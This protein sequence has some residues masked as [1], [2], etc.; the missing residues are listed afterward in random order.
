MTA[1]AQTQQCKKHLEAVARTVKEMSENPK[2]SEAYKI[3]R[4]QHQVSLNWLTDVAKIPPSE[5]FY[6][7]GFDLNDFK[8]DRS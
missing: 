1:N 8:G 4:A 2:D 5:L 3:A 6:L 7:A